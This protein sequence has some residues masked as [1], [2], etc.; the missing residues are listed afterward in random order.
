MTADLHRFSTLGDLYETL[1]ACD[2]LALLL[3]RLKRQ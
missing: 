1:D 2:E 3:S